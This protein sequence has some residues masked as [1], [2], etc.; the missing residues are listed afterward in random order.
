M[1]RPRA[2][3]C[4][5]TNAEDRDVAVAAGAHAVGFIVDVTVETAREIDAAKARSLA[6]GLPPFVTSVLVTMPE[7]VQEAVELQERV[8]ADV[9]QIHGGLAPEYIGGL[10]ERIDGSVVVSVHNDQEDIDEYAEPADLLLVDS[11]TDEGAGGTGETHDW[12]RTRELRERLETPVCLAGGLTPENVSEA[13]DAVEP[14]A[15]DVATGVEQTDGRKDH[16]AVRAFL[17]ASVRG[18]K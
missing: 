16:D 1:S 5:V 2:K 12:E 3:I 15:V 11:T 9:V 17:D 6:S 8:G 7:S 18:S 4:G 10:G 13:I 14:Y